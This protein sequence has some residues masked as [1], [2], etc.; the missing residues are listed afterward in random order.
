[1]YFVSIRRHYCCKPSQVVEINSHVRLC[2]WSVPGRA[3]E[4]ESFFSEVGGR[5]DWDTCWY[6][7][8]SSE[9]VDCVVHGSLPVLGIYAQSTDRPRPLPCCPCLNEMASL[10]K[11]IFYLWNMHA[12]FSWLASK[13]KYLL[14]KTMYHPTLCEQGLS[15]LLVK[16]QWILQSKY[17]PLCLIFELWSSVSI[18]FQHQMLVQVWFLPKTEGQEGLWQCI[19]VY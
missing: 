12:I 13:N 8:H 7:G 14:Q 6:L 19:L 4:R 2:V 9:A 17:W 16:A 1:M 10:V 3:N 5:E 15:C 11:T 18:S